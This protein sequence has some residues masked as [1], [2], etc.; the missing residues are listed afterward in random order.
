RGDVGRCAD[1]R[2][3]DLLTLQIGGGLD[4]ALDHELKWKLIGDAADEDDVSAL[5]GGG[6]DRRVA[7]LRNVDRATDDGLRQCRAGV[8]IDDGNVEAVLLKDALLHRVIHRRGGHGVAVIG[9]FERNERG[10]GGG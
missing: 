5:H 2:D 3:G 8:D 7:V 1:T 4:V 9:D 10:C 6:G